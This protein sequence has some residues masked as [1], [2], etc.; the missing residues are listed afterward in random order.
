MVGILDKL[1]LNKD[2]EST[3]NSMLQNI[4]TT[5]SQNTKLEKEIKVYKMEMKLV[6][7]ENEILQ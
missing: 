2:E 1:S 4:M 6:G 5:Q 7:K 3:L